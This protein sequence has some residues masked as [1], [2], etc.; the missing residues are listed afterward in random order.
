MLFRSLGL[1]VLLRLFAPF[2]P[3]VTEEVWSWAFAEETGRPSIH[4]APWPSAAELEA[5]PAP[6]DAGSLG[7]AIAAL[8]AVNKAKADAEVSMGREV[9]ALGLAAAPATLARAAPVLADVLAAARCASHRLEPASDVEEGAFRVLALEL[10][11]RDERD[12][13]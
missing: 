8:A 13:G 2:L 11:P 3:Y 4:R 1:S 5:V 6:A 9:A 12:R 10:A 7:L